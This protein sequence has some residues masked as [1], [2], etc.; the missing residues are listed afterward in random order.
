MCVR[1]RLLIEPGHLGS[2][3]VWGLED[4]TRKSVG[5]D[6]GKFTPQWGATAN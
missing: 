2:T 3:V 5:W 1:L 4:L 6:L